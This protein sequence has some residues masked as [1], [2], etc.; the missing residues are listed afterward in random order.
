MEEGVREKD[1]AYELSLEVFGRMHGLMQKKVVLRCLERLYGSPEAVHAEQVCALADG[2]R[3]NRVTL[4]DS[5]VAVLEYEKIRL[6]RGYKTAEPG[7]A[8]YCEPG[9]EYHYMGAS[10]RLTLENCEKIGEIPV[11]RYTKWFD[12]DKIKDNVILR[13]RRPGDYLEVAPGLHKKLKNYLIDQKVPKEVREQ[14]ILL[15]DGAHIIW[16][17]GMRISERYKVTKGTRRILKVQKMVHGGTDDKET[18]Y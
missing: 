9:G 6:K 14:L 2:R 7:E 13:T 1:G 5:C 3:G 8:V 12:Y 15:A 4:P 16:V 18:S 17:V 11:N 10:F